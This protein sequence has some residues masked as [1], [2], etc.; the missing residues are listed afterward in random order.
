MA[1]RQPATTGDGQGSARAFAQHLL[2]AE[3]ICWGGSLDS[4]GRR[5]QGNFAEA[6]TSQRCKAAAE[7]PVGEQALDSG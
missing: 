3:A 2:E 6:K 1:H 4:N 5:S 7:A